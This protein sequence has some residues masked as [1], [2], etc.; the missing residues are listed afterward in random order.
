M[1]RNEERHCA[2]YVT[3]SLSQVH[4]SQSPALT[5]SKA[6]SI[7]SMQV[8]QKLI[9][10]QDGPTLLSIVMTLEVTGLY[11][12]VHNVVST[13]G[14]LHG[15]LAWK[16]Q[17]K[18]SGRWPNCDNIECF[19]QRT[20]MQMRQACDASPSCTGFTF[21]RNAAISGGCLKACGC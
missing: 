7:V 4:T 9:K 17:P 11:S 6:H 10:V 3:L 20:S 1:Q 15:V 14:L 21:G 16:A 8:T 19:G 2:G 13:V 12:G 18:Y 5:T